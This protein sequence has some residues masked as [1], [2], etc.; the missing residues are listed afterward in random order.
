MI[1]TGQ[2]VVHPLSVRSC[3]AYN[4]TLFLFLF[5]LNLFLSL[6]A[7]FSH[8]P[9]SVSLG[10]SAVICLITNENATDYGDGKP[11]IMGSCD[12]DTVIYKLK[13]DVFQMCALKCTAT[14]PPQ[15]LLDDINGPLTLFLSALAGRSALA[16]RCLA[17]LLVPIHT[18]LR[19]TVPP[20]LARQDRGNPKAEM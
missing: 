1:P 2:F 8:Y 3:A 18:R 17:S 9:M 13:R 19:R 4:R 10:P 7:A 20:S 14:A 15:S 16:Y 12:F 5:L 11:L 6:W